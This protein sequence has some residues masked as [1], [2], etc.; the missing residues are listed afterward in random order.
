MPTGLPAERKLTPSVAQP[1]PVRA[2]AP[3]AASDGDSVRTEFARWSIDGPY[4]AIRKSCRVGWPSATVTRT[5]PG[6][7]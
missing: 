3:A 1:P 5:A 6:T 4:R 2:K 7:T